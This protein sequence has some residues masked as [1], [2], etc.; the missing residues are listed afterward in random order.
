[1]SKPK[2]LDLFCG[3]G[4]SAKG[5]QR[6]GFY[7]VGIDIESQPRYCGDEFIQADAL[8]P[9]VDLKAFDVIHASPPCQG[10]S[11][12]ANYNG[13]P[14]IPRSPL[15]IADVR[16]M[17]ESSGRI[18]VIENVMG[19]QDHLKGV[20]ICGTSLGLQVQRHRLFESNQCLFG[21]SPCNHL[22]GNVSVRRKKIE[23]LGCYQDA[24]TKKG[25][26]VRRAPATQ[27]SVAKNAM[28]IDWMQGLEL[29]DAIPPAYCEFIGRQLFAMLG[30]GDKG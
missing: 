6:A 11:L 19:A 29:G 27:Q 2:L 17:L 7:V 10:Y 13:R 15:L 30:G 20:V 22:P 8:K 23:L 9:P 1:M 14:A 18:W 25:M 28:G 4:G 24:V 16:S 12:G 21:S 3:A 5:Y 26:K